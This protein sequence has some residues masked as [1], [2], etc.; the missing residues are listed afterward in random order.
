VQLFG[1]G[2]LGWTWTSPPLRP[3]GYGREGT[4]YRADVVGTASALKYREDENGSFQSAPLS[5]GGTSGHPQQAT[6]NSASAPP[7]K[8]VTRLEV[9][10]EGNSGEHLSALS[11]THR[12]QR[13][14]AD[15]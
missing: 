9:E 11:L 8:R 15:T 2:R 10:A 13:A 3:G 4:F 12:P 6:I 1:G 14:A 5:P 7:W